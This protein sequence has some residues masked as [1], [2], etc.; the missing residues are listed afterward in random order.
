MNFSDDSMYNDDQLGI[1]ITPLVDIVFLLL[2]FF[3]VSTTFV[4][5][6]GIKVNLPSATTTPVTAEAKNLEISISNSGV[7][8]FKGEEIAAE[9]LPTLLR[10]ELES[11]A[12][13]VLVVRAD[14][15]AFHGIVVKVMD[16]ARSAGVERMA[17]ATIPKQ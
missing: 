1:D 17:V 11:G 12:Q 3:M 6:R 14:E 8:F 2:I 7:L 5:A 10:K 16:A 13:P 4:E 15:K 9:Q